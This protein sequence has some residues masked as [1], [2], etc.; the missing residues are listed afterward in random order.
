DPPPSAVQDQVGDD[1]GGHRHQQEVAGI[2]ATPVVSPR[3]LA[4]AIAVVVVDR[5]GAAVAGAVIAVAARPAR[6]AAVDDDRSRSVVAVAMDHAWRR[7]IDDA[8]IVAAVMSVTT[9][10]GAAVVAVAVVPIA[11]VAVVL[12]VVVA[13]AVA[14]VVV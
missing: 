4:Q 10:I 9:A 2:A 11:T 8:T 3:W 5:V 1:P 13:V 12:A 7:V 6:R 14:T